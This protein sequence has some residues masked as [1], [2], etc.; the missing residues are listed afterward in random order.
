MV[1]RSYRRVF[2]LERRIYRIDRLRLNPG[3]VPVRG[4]VYF[5]ALLLL[6]MALERMAPISLLAR[7]VPW[8]VRDL[9]LPGLFSAVLAVVR[10]EGRPFHL[11]A[12][13]VLGSGL[14]PRP[15]VGLSRDCRSAPA[16]EV[17][18]PQPL[19]MVPD[20][21]DHRMRRLTYRGPGA[22]LVAVAHERRLRGGPLARLGLRP[23]LALRELHGVERP[24][25]GEVVVLDPNARLRVY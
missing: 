13:A 24:V 22:L 25:R 20:G 9:A 14:G 17:W 23:Q 18:R 15:I 11:A 2:D 10:I 8:Y 12:R 5:I 7:V 6:T 1:I 21:S 4:I 19:L 3:G 16:R